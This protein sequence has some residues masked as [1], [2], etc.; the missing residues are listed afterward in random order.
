M[1]ILVFNSGSS[2]LKFQLIQMPEEKILEKGKIEAIGLKN[3]SITINNKQ[4][5][6]KVENFHKA[7]LLALKSLLDLD[8]DII[9]H[10]VVHG[11]EYFSSATLIKDNVIKK[12][13]SLKTLA[14]LHIPHSLDCIKAAMHNLPNIPQIAVFDTAFHQTIPE[15][16]YLYAIPREEYER[17]KIRKYGFHGISHK[18]VLSEAHRIL[19][20]KKLNAVSCHLGNGCS[21]CAIKNNKSIETS[22]GFTPL[23]GL[24]MGERSGDIDPAIISFISKSEK[25]SPDKVVSLLN[26]NSGLKG[27][28]GYKDMRTVHEHAVK[29]NKK[30][31]L[32]IKMFNQRLL[33]YIGAYLA[34]L[35]KTDCIIFTGGIGEGAWYVRQ[36]ICNSLG[37]ELDKEKNKFCLPGVISKNSK[38]SVLMIPT[39]EELEI[40][41]ETYSLLIKN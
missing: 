10:R 3:S 27:I 37:I 7:L 8:I 17:Y 30:C 13:E 9:A 36:E 33:E 35:K 19:K 21:V 22:M 34:L 11:G 20:R 32:A 31:Q 1:K 5:K 4:N 2:S 41:R 29:G 24:I 25:I 40:A 23:Q 14:P 39:N 38:L 28:S 12:I 26:N 6:I 18:Y 16:S 15:Q